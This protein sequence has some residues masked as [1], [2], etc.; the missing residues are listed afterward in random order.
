MRM[1][2]SNHPL[3]WVLA[4]I[5]KSIIYAQEGDWAGSQI[6][7]SFGRDSSLEDTMMKIAEGMTVKERETLVAEDWTERLEEL[8][9]KSGAMLCFA[10]VPKV[11]QYLQGRN[12]PKYTHPAA[13]YH[14]GTDWRGKP[15]IEPWAG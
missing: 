10:G 13:E 4:R 15:V 11:L 8:I 5:G 1:H 2:D 6:R 9:I 3:F 7:K 14:L 12:T